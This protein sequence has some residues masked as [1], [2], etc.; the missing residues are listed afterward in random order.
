LQTNGSESIDLNRIQKGQKRIQ[1]IAK[2]IEV[3][4]LISSYFLWSKA[5]VTVFV[6]LMLF[7]PVLKII[8]E[9]ESVDLGF[10]WKL[11]MDLWRRGREEAFGKIFLKK[12][13]KKLRC[14][15]AMADHCIGARPTTVEA[16]FH[17]LLRFVNL[18][19]GERRIC[20]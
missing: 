16:S 7:I 13:K 2:Q 14:G 4:R 1:S 3:F 8:F 19:R 5:K 17:L 20:V 15:G 18:E 11:V 9:N 10:V 12:I 6:W